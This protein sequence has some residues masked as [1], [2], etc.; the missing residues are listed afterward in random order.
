MPFHDSGRAKLLLSLFYPGVRGSCQAAW[1][2]SLSVRRTVPK[3]SKAIKS[4]WAVAP[5]EGDPCRLNPPGS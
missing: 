5:V 2:V 1:G 4:V 3:S